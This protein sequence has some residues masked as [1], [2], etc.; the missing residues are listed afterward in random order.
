M[1]PVQ[2]PATAAQDDAVPPGTEMFK[3][4]PP[5]TGRADPAV[6]GGGDGIDGVLQG[7]Q[8]MHGPQMPAYQPSES[9]HS[10]AA[11]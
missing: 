11:V 10:Q 3:S 4:T 6:A 1:E 2:L 7:P 9:L 8:P 5:V